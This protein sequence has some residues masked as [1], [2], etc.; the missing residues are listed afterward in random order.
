MRKMNDTD[1]DALCDGA[2]PA[3]AKRLRKLLADW[4]NGDEESFPV[5]LALLTRAQWRAAAAVPRF[6]NEAREMME[7]KLAEHRQQTAALIKGFADTAD[8]KVK[9][10]E[11][12]VARHTDTTKKTVAETRSQ[13]SNAEVAACRIR[14]ELEE[15][16]LEW[17]QAKAD[18]EAERHNLEQARKE[19]EAR[20][21]WRD[22]LWLALA[23]IGLIGIG[24]AI[25]MRVAR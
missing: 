17:K 18:F 20:Q 8:V 14:D 24:I 22:W 7:R 5:Q 9:A 11:D 21:N 10:L 2:S 6:I 19:L 3:E 25:G 12:I 4:C 1:F 13:L 23:L 16:A 15:G